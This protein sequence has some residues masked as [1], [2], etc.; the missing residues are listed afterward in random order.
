[1]KTAGLAFIDNAPDLAAADQ[2]RALASR[3]LERI[4]S[5]CGDN[6]VLISSGYRSPELNAAVGGATNSAHP[7]GCAA[8]FTIPGFGSVE[9]VCHAIKPHLAEFGIDQLIEE[10]GGG[11]KWV[12]VGRAI[13]RST[14]R[15]QRLTITNG[16]T[17]SGI[18]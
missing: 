10:S 17:I 7:F 13:P 11:A 15:G 1:M 2:L 5:L 4:R 12:H 16:E 14:P 3:T 9:D 6:P 18:A 8:D